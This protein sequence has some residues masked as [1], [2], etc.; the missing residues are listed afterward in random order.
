MALTHAVAY[1]LL[2]QGSCTQQSY[3]TNHCIHP[4]RP[5]E[6]ESLSGIVESTLKEVNT[7]LLLVREV[8]QEGNLQLLSHVDSQGIL[9]SKR[10]WYSW[11]IPE[12][13]EYQEPEP[14]T[15]ELE[16]VKLPIGDSR[17]LGGCS[18]RNGAVIFFENITGNMQG[19]RL[20]GGKWTL[21]E[22]IACGRQEGS[23]FGVLRVSDEMVVVFYWHTDK[24]LHQMTVKLQNNVYSDKEVSGTNFAT[25]QDF[26]ISE[27][28]ESGDYTAFFIVKESPRRALIVVRPNGERLEASENDWDW[29][30]SVKPIIWSVEQPEIDEG[31]EN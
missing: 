3:Y 17:E 28:G 30:G 15:T 18:T 14:E 9:H 5:R 11:V 21:M 6:P 24:G 19:I 25:H 2:A 22:P 20:S 23:P 29:Q 10:T 31:Q 13:E 4:D 26:I 12:T 7:P 16:S 1:E 27:A 8:A